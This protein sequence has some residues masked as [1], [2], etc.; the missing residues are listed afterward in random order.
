MYVIPNSGTRVFIKEHRDAAVG[1][2]RTRW[3]RKR[4]EAYFAR[5]LET[6]SIECAR[7][8]IAAMRYAA[9][10]DGE[11]GDT[12]IPNFPSALVSSAPLTNDEGRYIWGLRVLNGLEINQRLLL[13]RSFSDDRKLMDARRFVDYMVEQLSANHSAD[14]TKRPESRTAVYSS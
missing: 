9:R 14:G 1:A 5:F 8:P 13:A 2:A 3:G 4:A 11:L 12:D 10:R 7:H 6:G